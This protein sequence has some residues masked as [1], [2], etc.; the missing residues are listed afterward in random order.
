LADLEANHER[1]QYVLRR[2]LSRFG[3][4][5]PSS[6]R[7]STTSSQRAALSRVIH[8]RSSESGSEGFAFFVAF[9]HS[10]RRVI[11]RP[12]RAGF[13][14]PRSISASM[15]GGYEATHLNQLRKSMFGF[16]V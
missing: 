7:C 10:N 9:S 11:S 4:R 2:V 6:R 12:S 5:S 15:A 8:S 14:A 13:E 3:S 16:Q 1:L